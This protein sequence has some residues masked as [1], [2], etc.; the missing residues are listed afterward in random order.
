ML[1]G[2]V[3][4]VACACTSSGV[5]GLRPLPLGVSAPQG[6]GVGLECFSA[7]GLKILLCCLC[8]TFRNL[9]STELGK[10]GR[11]AACRTLLSEE[12]TS[13]MDSHFFV[14][15]ARRGTITAALP[16]SDGHPFIATWC[17]VLMGCIGE[18]GAALLPGGHLV[19]RSQ[20]L[21]GSFP[22]SLP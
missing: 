6:A 3:S 22:S 8:F 14:L 7:V 20:R 15:W 21:Q 1:Y 19:R 11:S 16:C 17:W 13:V 10:L 18:A 12:P 9:T 2:V 5:S 4:G